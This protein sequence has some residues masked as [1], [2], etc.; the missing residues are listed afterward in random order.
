MVDRIQ[1]DR[2]VRRKCVVLGF[3]RQSYYRRKAGH[4]PEELDAF[5]ADLLH[6]VTTRFIAWG[7]WMVFHYL[8]N[9]GYSWNHK[10][11][12]RIWKAE[13]LHLRVPPKRPKIRRVYQD[14][15]APGQVNEGWAMDFLS[16]WVV[17][18][19]QEKVRIINVV[20][21]L[22]PREESCSRKALWTEAHTNISA[23]KL[24]EVLDKIVEWRGKPSYI[25]CDNGP[26]FISHRLQAWADKHK[27]E[28]KFIQPGKPSQNGIIERLNGTLRRE[29][30]N[31]EWFES[32]TKLNEQIQDWW[33]VYNSI[34]PHSS[35]GYKTPDEY[36]KCKQNFYFSMVAA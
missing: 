5:I 16:D 29:C 8:R 23:K 4:R 18:P 28:L 14:L 34:R 19:A 20:E 27:I 25:R 15:L 9:Q 1:P 6:Q 11:V 35:I 3:R 17:G 26:E 33:E 24:I 21:D 13:Q 36:E 10:K 32:I 2:S 31:L 7:F 22:R 12:Y 30:L